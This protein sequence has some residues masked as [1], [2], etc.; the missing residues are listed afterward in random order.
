MKSCLQKMEPSCSALFILSPQNNYRSENGSFFQP[1]TG[2]RLPP[3]HFW[4]FGF[5]L[6][7]LDWKKNA[8]NNAETAMGSTWS[9]PN[10]PRRERFRRTGFKF[11]SWISAPNFFCNQ[12][13]DC[14]RILCHLSSVEVSRTPKH[15]RR[16]WDLILP[17]G[18]WAE[19]KRDWRTGSTSLQRRWPVPA[20]TATSCGL[21]VHQ[22]GRKVRKY[23]F[24]NSF[25]WLPTKDIAVLKAGTN[26][27]L[28]PRNNM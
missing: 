24:W 1:L 16:L 11:A 4:L 12:R 26:T 23:I 9:T 21:C 10:T 7:G 6:V 18:S 15:I 19:N 25:T 3:G 8:E 27:D 14:E 2:E 13:T 20:R 28:R 5:L 22:R 17:R